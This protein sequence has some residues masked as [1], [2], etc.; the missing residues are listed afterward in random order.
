VAASADC[1]RGWW[2]CC[3]YPSWR[4]PTPRS[5]RPCARVAYISAGVDVAVNEHPI[6]S[7]TLLPALYARRDYTPVWSNPDSVRQLISAIEHIDADG[8]DPADF[9]LATLRQLLERNNE[10]GSSRPERTANLDLLLTGSL[11]R[12]VRH[13][14]L[15][16]SIRRNSTPSGTRPVPARA[17]TRCCRG[18][19]P[20]RPAA[21]TRCCNR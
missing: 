8:L 19:T 7:D 21:S 20:S 14:S 9:N 1:C 18:R 6:S 13:L 5:A 2:S 4:L 12:L 3:R 17:S 11:I 10:T 15:A 16:K